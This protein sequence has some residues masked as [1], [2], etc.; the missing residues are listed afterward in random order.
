[1]GSEIETAGLG[2]RMT[3]RRVFYAEMLVFEM[4]IANRRFRENAQRVAVLRF[5]IYLAGE[6]A[7]ILCGA[8]SV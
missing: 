8:D 3:N 5:G 2:F 4:D 6:M 7:G 1:M